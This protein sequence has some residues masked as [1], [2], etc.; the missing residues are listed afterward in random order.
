VLRAELRATR[1]RR[2]GRLVNLAL[3]GGGWPRITCPSGP[4]AVTVPSAWNSTCQPQRWMHTSWWKSQ[5][6]PQP[7]TL[8]GP[9]SFL[10]MRWCTSQADGG[11]SQPPGHSQCRARA[12]TARRIGSGIWSLYPTSSGTLLVLNGAGRSPVRSTEA[13][14]PGPDT[15]LIAS[16]PI[17]YISACHA[18][19]GS[20]SG[21]RSSAA[22]LVPPCLPSAS[23][24]RKTISVMT[25]QSGAAVTRG[26]MSASHAATSASLPSSQPRSPAF[27]R[28]QASSRTVAPSIW[29]S[30]ENGMW[31]STLVS[32]PTLPGTIFAPMS[33]SQA[34]CSAS[35]QRCSRVRVS[36]LP[37]FLPRDSR[38]ACTAAAP[39]AVRLPV[40]RPTL[41]I[42][43][44]SRTYRSSKPSSG[45]SGSGR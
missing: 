15:N 18:S 12:I 45:S 20:G 37:R 24:T 41:S 28:S 13:I 16:L 21:G 1:A 4:T 34:S 2:R 10:W 42:V 3:D 26:T 7:V 35:C 5:N 32:A 27:A 44:L 23:R 9:P 36:S 8:V 43:V 31:T 30:W 19:G 33:S 39:S 29:Q 11:R 22:S 17:A 14:A 6:S 25:G 38:T 40:S